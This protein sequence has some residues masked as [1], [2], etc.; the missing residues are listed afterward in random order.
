MVGYIN[1]AESWVLFGT[2]IAQANSFLS[3][4]TIL[5]LKRWLNKK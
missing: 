1:Q 4:Y 5:R 2:F 3:I